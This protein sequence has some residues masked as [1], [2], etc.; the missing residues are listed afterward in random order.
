MIDY[1]TRTYIESRNSENYTIMVMIRLYVIIA[2]K[3]DD[4]IQGLKD[5]V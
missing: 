2:I 1:F 4:S 5:D 3:Y